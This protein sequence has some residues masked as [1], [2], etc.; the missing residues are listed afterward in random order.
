MFVLKILTF[1]IMKI[2]A[3]KTSYLFLLGLG[4]ILSSCV[5]DEEGFSE[6]VQNYIDSITFQDTVSVDLDVP[7][8]T[9]QDMIFYY[10][11]DH[12]FTDFE[13]N[14]FGDDGYEVIAFDEDDDI[15]LYLTFKNRPVPGK[16]ATDYFYGNPPSTDSEVVMEYFTPSEDFLTLDDD[17]IYVEKISGGA[18][19]FSFCDVQIDAGWGGY[20]ASGNFEVNLKDYE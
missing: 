16:Y 9:P 4:F 2:A 14:D 20:Y 3:M 11:Y 6:F 19:V 7:C 13:C 18:L 12:S 8:T 1:A 17:T 15:Y 10:T 5:K